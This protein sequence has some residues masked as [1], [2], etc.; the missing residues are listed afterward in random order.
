LRLKDKDFGLKDKDLKLEDKDL[1]LE[2]KDKD[3]QSGPRGQGLEAR[4]QQL[5]EWSSRTRTSSKTQQDWVT[6]KMTYLTI[7]IADISK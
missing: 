1:R 5:A 6:M 4:G 3:L 2:D 7:S